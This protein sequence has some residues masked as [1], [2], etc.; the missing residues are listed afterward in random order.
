M[1]ELRL[2]IDKQSIE[3]FQEIQI[4]NLKLITLSKLKLRLLQLNII[5][6]KSIVIDIDLREQP[7][8]S[9]IPGS[10]RA[11]NEYVEYYWKGLKNDIETRD[12]KIN[13]IYYDLRNR[14][15]IDYV[16]VNTNL[17]LR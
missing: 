16:G 7:F 14:N 4:Q 10:V 1:G 6:N 8:Q 17:G 11:P 5:V 13:S 12:F 2:M 3:S 9:E 15:I